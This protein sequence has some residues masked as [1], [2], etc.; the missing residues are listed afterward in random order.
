MG[1]DQRNLHKKIYT[2]ILNS[3]REIGFLYYYISAFYGLTDRG[4]SFAQKNQT[5]ILISG[6]ENR[7][8][9]LRYLTDGHTDICN[10]RLVSLTK[11]KISIEYQT[12]S[13]FTIKWMEP[14]IK[15]HNRQK[16]R[17]TRTLI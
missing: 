6:R 5:Y 9:P 8:S 10:Y 16:H 17:R 11:N 3:N 15:Y 14:I 12:E 7:R 4:Q 2:S 1:I 13:R